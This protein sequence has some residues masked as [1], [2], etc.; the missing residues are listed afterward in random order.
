MARTKLFVMYHQL[1]FDDLGCY[2]HTHPKTP[3]LD[4]VA[5]TEARFTETRLQSPVC[6][7]SRRSTGTGRDLHSRGAAS[8]SSPLQA[9]GT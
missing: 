7:S 4:R 8:K 3:N 5:A 9:G 1:R 6:G 2:G